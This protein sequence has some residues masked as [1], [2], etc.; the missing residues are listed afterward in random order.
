MLLS[1]EQFLPRLRSY[2]RVCLNVAFSVPKMGLSEQSKDDRDM[3][4]GDQK[5]IF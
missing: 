2:R 5:V 4:E 3:T 1:L